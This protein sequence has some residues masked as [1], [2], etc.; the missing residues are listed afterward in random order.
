M[1]QQRALL[2]SWKIN[3]NKTI[4]FAHDR[5]IKDFTMYRTNPMRKI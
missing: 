1:R 4:T 2:S 3:T 5:K